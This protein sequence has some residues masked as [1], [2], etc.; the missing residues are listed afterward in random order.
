MTYDKFPFQ[1]GLITDTI[2]NLS[3]QAFNLYV[4]FIQELWNNKDADFTSWCTTLLSTLS[5]A[6]VLSMILAECLLKSL[7]QINLVSQ[8]GNIGCH[9]AQHTKKR[10]SL[11]YCQ[12]GLVLYTVSLNCVK[13]FDTAHHNLLCCIIEK[14]GLQPIIIQN[15]KK[16]DNNCKVKA[17]SG[18]QT[19]KWITPL[20][21][22]R[23]TT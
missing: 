6:K 13:A 5:S 14:Y 1:S 17:K 19:W 4:D 10:A 20:E 9:E 11:L 21:G 7:K 15:V 22:N 8:F 23:V 12:Y 16:L 18:K 2:N 3:P